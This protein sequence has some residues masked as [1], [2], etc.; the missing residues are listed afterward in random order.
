MGEPRYAGCFTLLRSV[1]ITDGEAAM[2]GMPPTGGLTGVK[3]SAVCFEGLSVETQEG[4]KATLAIIDENGQIIEAG[5]AVAR[6]AWNVTLAC[7][8]NFLAGQGHLR[9]FSSPPGGIQ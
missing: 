8:K 1:R 5:P 9:V 2:I 3:L 6:E 4:R 7:Y